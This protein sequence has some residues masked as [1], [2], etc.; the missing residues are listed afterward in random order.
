MD[1]IKENVLNI[2]SCFRERQGGWNIQEAGSVYAD[3]TE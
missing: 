1:F 3:F 2:D